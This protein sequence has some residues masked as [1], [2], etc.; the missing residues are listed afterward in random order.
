MYILP[1]VVAPH[2][3][4]RE[5]FALSTFLYG[6]ND[7]TGNR[8]QRDKSSARIK[9]L[10]KSILEYIIAEAVLF[11]TSVKIFHRTDFEYCS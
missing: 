11:K 9:Y 6:Y 8:I 1:L 2:P 7:N 3:S 4:L 5:V 10:A